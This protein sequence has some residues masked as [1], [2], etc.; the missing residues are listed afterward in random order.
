MM[1]VARERPTHFCGRP[2]AYV[3]VTGHDQERP[4]EAVEE[5]RR[6][7]VGAGA[8]VVG[9]VA[10]HDDEAGTLGG[11][12]AMEGVLGRCV[13]SGRKVEVG[14]VD[15]THGAVLRRRQV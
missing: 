3:M 10:G 5:P 9:Q 12:Q 4:P 13:A 15:E 1:V 11:D 8:A 7:G 6:F 2:D 14:Q